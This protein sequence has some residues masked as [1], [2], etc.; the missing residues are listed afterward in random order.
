MFLIF[1][2]CIV[3]DERALSREFSPIFEFGVKKRIMSSMGCP[4]GK[5][6][7]CSSFLSTYMFLATQFLSRHCG[8]V[9][10]AMHSNNRA[11]ALGFPAQVRILLMSLFFC[12]LSS[13]LATLQKLNWFGDLEHQYFFCPC[14][15][16]PFGV[17]I[18]LGALRVVHNAKAVWRKWTNLDV[19][20]QAASMTVK[21]DATRGE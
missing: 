4:G 6:I 1:Y 10:K 13:L 21:P 15:P 12:F 14:L 17:T 20:S 9:V 7:L 3:H 11:H 19:A 18:L 2:L 8:R 5:T 16:N